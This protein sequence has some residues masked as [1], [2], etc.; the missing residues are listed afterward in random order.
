MARLSEGFLI[1]ASNDT[2]GLIQ[3]SFLAIAL[4]QTSPS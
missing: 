1:D 4:G 3:K 2:V